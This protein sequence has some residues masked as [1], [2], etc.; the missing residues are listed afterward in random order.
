MAQYEFTI[1]IIGE[2]E[3]I[4]SAWED[5]VMQFGLAPVRPATGW[6]RMDSDD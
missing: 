4:D 6:E 5:A 1:T 2:G 3:T